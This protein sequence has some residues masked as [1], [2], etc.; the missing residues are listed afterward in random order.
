MK[1]LLISVMTSA[2]L[3]F[4][5]IVS[6]A[7]F[8]ASFKGVDINE[9]VNTVARNLNKTIIV[10]PRVQGKINVRSYDVLDE[11]QYY[12]FFLSVLDVYGYSVVPLD[13]GI[14]KIVKSNKA[15]T[16]GLPV[17]DDKN[18]GL[19]D[20]MIT[21]V[22]S[23]KNVSVRDL[24]TLLRQLNDVAE[25]GNVAH[26]EPSNVLIIT[27]RANVVN[28]LV[29]IV[30]RVDTAGDQDVE[31]VTLKYASATE[32]ARIINSLLKE[33]SSSK[34]V[35]VLLVPTVA[36]DERTNSVIISGDP[37]ARAR[38][39]K[40]IEKLDR[41]QA[42][43]GNTRV[44]YLKYAK[45]KNV[46]EVLSGVGKEVAAEKSGDTAASSSGSSNSKFSI[47]ADEDTN[48]VIISAQP[49]VM[50]EMEDIIAKLDIRRAQVYVEAIIAEISTGN[51]AQLGI[52]WG[53]IEGGAVMFA[54]DTVQT[55]AASLLS[56][57]FNGLAGTQGGMVGFFRGNWFGLMTALGTD[58]KSD[59]LSTPSVVTLDN[60]EAEF[61]VG[62]EV[63]VLTGT[64][65]N[66]ASSSSDTV[67]Q[68]IERKEVG[69]KLK[70]TPQI[71]EGDSV[72]LDIEQEV[73]SVDS[74]TASSTLGPT[75]NK[76][77]IKNSVMV[78]SGDTVVIGGLM[79]HNTSE[80]VYKVPLLGDIPVFGELF[81]STHTN[82]EK[83]NLVVF[84]RPIILR[85]SDSYREMSA[86]KYTRLR[87]EQIRRNEDGLRLLPSEL[88][89][90]VVP[91]YGS[92]N[93]FLFGDEYDSSEE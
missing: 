85:D 50:K 57:G 10:A 48:A 28:R 89:S 92:E 71:N 35:S 93:G 58:S 1:K 81:K 88:S 7:Q 22:V 25:G 56:N 9:F 87:A 72:R 41:D 49:D 31:S 44:I 82:Y 43:T 61:D 6:A 13:N 86:P 16:S 64:Q 19:G 62:Q 23:V 42:Y 21:R 8:S 27:G 51:T 46:L 65:Q 68:T 32:V 30:R 73:S 12:Q 17:V 14:L 15:K 45:A 59:V 4:S 24:S 36:A 47:Y 69:T 90:P 39:R 78:R 11:G 52:Q 3:A 70:F 38:V 18:P 63:P 2:A 20:E 40:I 60:Q 84:I 37:K 77:T 83:R 33:S 74:A 54:G 26:Y 5:S 67:Y 79:N 53:N 91:K 34:S 66:L 55:S 75:F 80:L 76:R 29:E